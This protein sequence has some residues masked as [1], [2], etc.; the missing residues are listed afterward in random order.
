QVVADRVVAVGFDGDLDLGD[1]TVG[2]R[3]EHRRAHPRRHAELSPEPAELA[4]RARRERRLDQRF[5]A[6]LGGI[7]RADVDAG[8]LVIERHAHAGS[9]CST[10][11]SRWKSST[12][13]AISLSSISRNRVI[14]NRSTANEPI[15]DPYTTAR[16]ML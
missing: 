12:R 16:R 13:A 11:T 6:L 2:A 9:S 1:H 5:D 4:A 3:H 7:G 8:V 15:A 14:E 10:L